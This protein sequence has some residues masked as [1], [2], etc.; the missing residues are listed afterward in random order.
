MMYDN[1]HTR[2]VN[3][4]KIVLPLLALALLSTIFLVSRR[5]DPSAAIPYAK[6]DVEKLARE[7]AVTRPEYSGVTDTGAT[8]SVTAAMAR[9]QPAQ[10]QG[11][12][13]D[14]VAAKLTAPD[15]HVTD[16]SANE[17]LFQPNSN[18]IDLT[19]KVAMQTSDGYRV[20]SEKIELQTDSSVLTS[21]GPIHG[22]SPF[23]T[24]D[25]GYMQIVPTADGSGHDLVFKQGV[26]LVYQPQQ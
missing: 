24:L 10:D 3:W 21:P 18:R 16:L 26:K 6:V 15:G 17:G 7:N 1:S 11:A 22:T 5:I 14:Q 8:L 19:G 4:A 23:G 2:L 13:A 9:T 12:S 20:N 25:A